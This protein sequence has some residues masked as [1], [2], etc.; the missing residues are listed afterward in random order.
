MA[1]GPA[2]GYQGESKVV[3]FGSTDDTVV[4]LVQ[5]QGGGEYAILHNGQWEVVFDMIIS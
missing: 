1:D 5:E 3:I 4:G 2:V